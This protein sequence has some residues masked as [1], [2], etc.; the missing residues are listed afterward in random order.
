MLTS[1]SRV[2]FFE[3]D[4]STPSQ[5]IPCILCNLKVQ[6]R[7]HNIQPC[8]PL[9]S[10]II[11]STPFHPVTLRSLSI[12]YSVIY[13]QVFQLVSFLQVSTPSHVPVSRLL[14]HCQLTTHLHLVPRLRMSGSIPLLPIYSFMVWIES[15]LPLDPYVPHVSVK[16]TVAQ[17]VK[18]PQGHK[19][20]VL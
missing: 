15:A 19:L 20:Q 14:K 6:Y 5:E 4:S 10:H 8:V 12:F 9:L 3:A 13:T 18:Y 16:L 2:F 1:G 17:S 7:V 11:Q